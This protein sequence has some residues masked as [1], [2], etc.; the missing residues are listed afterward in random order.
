MRIQN[1]EPS[2]NFGTC[3]DF[4]LLSDL[5]GF[6]KQMG[7]EAARRTKKGSN[8]R[9]HAALPTASGIN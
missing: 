5:L 8:F 3:L 4:L 9:K 1:A 6:L 2:R 7:L